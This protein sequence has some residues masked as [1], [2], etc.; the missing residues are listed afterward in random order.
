MHMPVKMIT[1]RLPRALPMFVEMADSSGTFVV[2]EKAT[3][4]DWRYDLEKREGEAIRREIRKLLRCGKLL[5]I[6]PDLP[7]LPMILAHDQGGEP[8]SLQ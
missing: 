7:L 8:P 5:G 4:A 1:V 3:T 2:A 6:A